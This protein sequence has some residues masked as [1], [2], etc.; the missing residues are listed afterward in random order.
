MRLRAL[1]MQWKSLK[2][3]TAEDA[4]QGGRGLALDD[5]ILFFPTSFEDD[6]AC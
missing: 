3:D 6:N 1:S 4:V 5:G 2:E